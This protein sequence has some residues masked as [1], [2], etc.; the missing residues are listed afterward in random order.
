LWS[1]PERLY[2][3][4]DGVDAGHLY[5]LVHRENLHLVAESGGKMLF[6]NRLLKKF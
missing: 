6:S 2:V 4:T 5:D 3:L 1:S